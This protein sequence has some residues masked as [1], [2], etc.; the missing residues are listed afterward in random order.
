[1]ETIRDQ[2]VDTDTAAELLGVSATSVRNYAKSGLLQFM[3]VSG[4]LVYPRSEVLTL[5]KRLDAKKN[6]GG[7]R[8]RRNSH[9]GQD[10]PLLGNGRGKSFRKVY[11]EFDPDG[12]LD[13]ASRIADAYGMSFSEYVI[14]ALRHLNSTMKR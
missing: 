1:M 10:L 13:R 12:T 3:K 7:S 6:N 4:K 8:R 2:F 11:R 9:S 5:R 14:D